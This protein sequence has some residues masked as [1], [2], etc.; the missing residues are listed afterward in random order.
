MKIVKAN[1][2]VTEKELTCFMCK[3]VLLVTGS[4]MTF[5]E[6]QRDGDACSYDCPV[7]HRENWVSLN[8]LPQAMID[9]AMGRN[10]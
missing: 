1:P 7:C 6:D 9:Q 2:P 3:S 5:H 4:D 8:L 10:T